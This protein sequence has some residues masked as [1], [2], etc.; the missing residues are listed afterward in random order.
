MTERFQQL[1]PALLEVLD[2]DGL[3]TGSDV[4]QR[5]DCWPGRE[6]SRALAVMLP[7][8]TTQVSQLLHL[9]HAAGQ[10]VVTQGGRTGLVH[11]TE[12]ASDEIILSLERMTAIEDCNPQAATITVQ[13]GVPLQSV[14]E[15]A[16]QHGLMFPL[17]LGSRGSC[18]IG[19]NIATNA[20]GMRV[21]RYGMTRQQ[22]LGLEVVLADGTVLDSM[23][24]MI[25]NNAGYDLK[26]LFIGSEGTLGVI[27]RAV[28]RLQPLPGSEQ[29]ALLAVPSFNALTRLLH[30]LNREL[31]GRLS[32]FEVMWQS[33]YRT[34]AVESG[35]H[36]PPLPADQPWYV[37][38]EALGSEPLHD[39]EQF[40]RVLAQMLEQEL[41]VDAVI[42]QSRAQRDSLWAIREDIPSIVAAM[43]PPVSFDVSLPIEAMERYVQGVEQALRE[44]FG[45]RGKLLVFGHLGD[46][47]LHLVT[48]VGDASAETRRAIEQL[49]YT[50]LQALGGSVSAEHGIG[51]EKRDY[52]QLSRTPEE[53]ALM[54]LLK[55]SLDPKGLLNPGKVIA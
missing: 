2:N 37:M 32:A 14:Q 41:A 1:R 22:V 3:L 53:I 55:R 25:K 10:P 12:T 11:G 34:V 31:G 7:R 26:Q 33:H 28:L 40:E 18:T 54:Q 52:L 19:G 29:N 45:E 42:A 49:V 30:S 44:Q 47:N 21:I 4:A 13:A 43:M 24:R 17:D 6:P 35:K 50:P 23:N 51:L 9:C 15:L 48:S 5:S 36:I 16:E 46:G 27:T 8:N 20:G 38:V 39:A